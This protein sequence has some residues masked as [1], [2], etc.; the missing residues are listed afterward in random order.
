MFGNALSPCGFIQI[1]P[2]VLWASGG[3]GIPLAIFANDRRDG[4]AT[5]QAR[6]L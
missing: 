1:N 6:F 2:E 5:Y 4:F 3:V